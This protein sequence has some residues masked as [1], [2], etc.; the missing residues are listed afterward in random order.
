MPT[1][2]NTTKIRTIPQ[3][4][5]LHLWCEAKARQLNESG[6][7]LSLVFR[8]IQA[9]Y[10]MELVKEF[11]RLFAKA[12]FGKTSTA[13]LTTKQLQDVF[14]EVDRHFAQF[15]V[16]HIPFPSQSETESYLATMFD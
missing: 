15:G 4:K 3:N 1:D 16:E 11:W 14:D 7:A 9:D 2:K 8:N 13:Q 12:K 6:I 5:A 10:S